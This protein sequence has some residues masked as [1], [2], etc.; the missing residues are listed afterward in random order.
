MVLASRRLD[1]LVEVWVIGIFH[2]RIDVNGV[3]S[4]EDFVAFRFGEGIDVEILLHIDFGNTVFALFEFIEHT[5]AEDLDNIANLE[6]GHGVF[7]NLHGILHGYACKM[8]S[9]AYPFCFLHIP[10]FSRHYKHNP[11]SRP[12][13]IAC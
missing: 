8:E 11:V 10:Q 6:F 3:M 12:L 7:P 4:D 5:P 2:P 9:H 1:D 13:C